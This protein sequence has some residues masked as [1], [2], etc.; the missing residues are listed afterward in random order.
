MDEIFDDEGFSRIEVLPIGY[1]R[2]KGGLFERIFGKKTT[3]RYI[4]RTK[5]KYDENFSESI[6]SGSTAREFHLKM[7]F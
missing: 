3:R 7:H 1:K 5:F 2:N 6:R 4:R